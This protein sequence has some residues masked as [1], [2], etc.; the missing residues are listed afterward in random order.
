MVSCKEET[1]K[2]DTTD[3]ETPANEVKDSA[4]DA[5]TAQQ[6]GYALPGLKHG[7]SQ[8]PIN[9]DTQS[10]AG[11]S[12]HKIT[13]NFKDEVNKV[14]NLGHTVQLDF[15]EGST[16]S[17]DGENFDFIQCHFH[18]PSEHLVDGMTYPM[19]MHIVNV[20]P[21]DDK[22]AQTEYL[23]V[24]TLFKEGKENPFIAE[25]LSKIPK[26]EKTSEDVDAGE[27]KLGDLFS[28]V[29]EGMQG[30]YYY[31]KGSLTTPPFT[32]S[33]RWYVSKHVFEASA[34]QIAAINEVEGNNARHVQ[35]TYG[36]KVTSD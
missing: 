12:Q 14:E 2:E 36:R 5:N 22:D 3:A 21:N 1:K 11:E 19:E 30:D 26:S 10:L 31:Y 13:M 32:E 25:F 18:T 24:S 34:A 35:A 23:V 20:M 15:K 7:L 8:S 29:P 27:I 6:Q 28:A 16:I 33:V 4:P 9:I 17:A